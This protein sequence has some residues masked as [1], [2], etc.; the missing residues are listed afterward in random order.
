MRLT[1]LLETN[2][3]KFGEYPFLFYKEKQCTNVETKQYADKPK[4]WSG[5][6]FKDSFT[7]NC[8]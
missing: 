7:Q 5:E 2:I 3:D 6:N 8:S 4:K 1:E